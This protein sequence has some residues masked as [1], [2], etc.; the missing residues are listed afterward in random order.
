M[1]TSELEERDG[2]LSASRNQHATTIVCTSHQTAVD[3]QDDLGGEIVRDRLWTVR[4][5][6]KEK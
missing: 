1:K 2:V 5:A 4:I 6:N 3:I